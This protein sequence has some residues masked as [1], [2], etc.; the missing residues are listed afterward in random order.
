MERSP[1]VARAGRRGA[2]LLALVLLAACA[3]E[4]RQF[5]ASPSAWAPARGARLAE[6]HVGSDDT[7]QFAPATTPRVDIG[8]VY[9]G[10]A[11][12][13]N[14][15]KRWFVAYN[16]SGCHGNGGGGMGPALMDHVWKYGSEPRDVYE[17]IVRGR[18]AGMPSFSGRIPERQ[19]W[20][21]VAYVR[22]MSGQAHAVAAPGRGEDM[23][24]VKRPE[25]SRTRETPVDTAGRPEGSR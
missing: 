14:E 5:H 19:V 17:S 9:D 4:T 11:Y 10:R 22:S 1:R 12:D 2:A 6:N 24:A 8:R 7:T 16:C 25:N 21:L 3:R 15:G 13:L 23:D 18:P 20:Q